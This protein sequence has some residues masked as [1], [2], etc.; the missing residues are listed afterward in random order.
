MGKLISVVGNTGVGKTTLVK[1]LCQATGFIQE[2]EENEKRPFQKL[3]FQDRQ[4][5]ALANQIDFLLFRLDQEKVVRQG[6]KTGVHDGGLDQDYHVFT[7]LFYQ[8]GYLNENEFY[9][10]Q[11]TYLLIREM[12]PPPDIYIWLGASIGRVAERFNSRGREVSIALVED[13]AAIEDLL[14]DWLGEI[15]E[16]KIIKINSEAEDHNYQKA[17]AQVKLRIQSMK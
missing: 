11:R 7:K 2:L 17:I 9:L 14:E 6:I 1:N 12:L 4:R 13:M 8:K 3:F 16:S 15:E 5:F 10:C